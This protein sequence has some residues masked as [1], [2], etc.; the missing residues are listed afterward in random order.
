VAPPATARQHRRLE[1]I[2]RGLALRAEELAGAVAAAEKALAAAEGKDEQAEARRKLARARR[3]LAE[4]RE[5][6]A[7]HV[8]ALRAADNG[9]AAERAG[10]EARRA[11]EARAVL[12][13]LRRRAR[14]F[15]LAAVEAEGN[16]YESAGTPEASQARWE[17]EALRK[18][19]D[20][21][22]ERVRAYEAELREGRPE[23]PPAPT[24][25]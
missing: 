21:L 12:G 5:I 4:C 24:G 25:G 1:H 17:V 15:E 14:L 13:R 11:A 20:R 9:A 7:E 23:G 3:D 8:A 2:A 6:L 18:I 19:R 16:L 22:R 10:A